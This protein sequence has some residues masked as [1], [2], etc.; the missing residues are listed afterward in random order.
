M[1][2]CKK[3]R[4]EVKQENPKW[5]AKKITDELVKMWDLTNEAEEDED[6]DEEEECLHG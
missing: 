1:N 6:E 4:A 2:F 5:N 3:H